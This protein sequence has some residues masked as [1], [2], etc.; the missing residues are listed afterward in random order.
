LFEA[1]PTDAVSVT[2]LATRIAAGQACVIDCRDSRQYR[3]GRIPGSH[4]AIRS[5]F[6]DVLGGLPRGVTLTF[7]SDDG[8][9]ATFAAADAQD[10]GFKTDHLAGG[11]T[12]WIAAGMTVESGPG[13]Y[14]SETNDAW[15]SPYQVES[16]REDAMRAYIAWE[17]GLLER[18]ADEPGLR[19]RI[20]EAR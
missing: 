11:F 16:G 3:K 18:L 2:D 1:A 7:V 13:R 19:F 15:Y 17:T 4:F 20:G 8:V 5:E 12:A 9:L 14:L 6:A 10:L